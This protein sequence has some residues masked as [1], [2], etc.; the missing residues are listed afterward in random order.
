MTLFLIHNSKKT[1]Y[2]F[3]TNMDGYQ[4]EIQHYLNTRGRFDSK[5][6]SAAHCIAHFNEVF[7]LRNERDSAQA[8]KQQQLPTRKDMEMMNTKIKLHS[9][10]QELELMKKEVIIE[11]LTRQINA[12]KQKI[13]NKRFSEHISNVTISELKKQHKVQLMNNRTTDTCFQI[14]IVLMFF[15]LFIYY[16]I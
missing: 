16:Y 3:I 4:P 14:I 2:K 13:A 9:H 7:K 10:H 5:E 15:F 6:Q 1:S 11:R 8:M 12:T